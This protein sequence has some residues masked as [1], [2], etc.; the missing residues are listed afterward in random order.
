M[1][2]RVFRTH[3]EAETEEIEV[4]A[5]DAWFAIQKAATAH[6][7][8][9]TT[10]HDGSPDGADPPPDTDWEA[11]PVLPDP[12]ETAEAMLLK[13]A[14]RVLILEQVP[15]TAERTVA[16]FAVADLRGHGLAAEYED[17]GGGTMCIVVPMPMDGAL[18]IGT[19]SGRGWG[20]AAGSGFG[21][22]VPG[23]E[24]T[25]TL[26]EQARAIVVEAIR[27]RNRLVRALDEWRGGL[28]A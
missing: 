2:Y 17:T 5:A 7:N 10:F 6:E 14:H 18:V 27:L 21:A 3:F 9:E 25:R 19:A 24:L 16:E 8:G 26:T 11:E 12:R 1:K 15:P 13:N 28:E 4:D 20:W 22:E 23:A